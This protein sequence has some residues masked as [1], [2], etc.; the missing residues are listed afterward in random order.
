MLNKRKKPSIYVHMAMITCIALL[1]ILG[2]FQSVW[3]LGGSASSIMVQCGLQRTRM[4]AI[5]K[6]VLILAYRP[7]AD[8]AQAIGE[9]QIVLPLW[10]QTQK[11]L[12]V[13]D[14]TLM[15]PAHVPETVQALMIASQS[16]YLAIDTAAKKIIADGPVDP[17]QAQIILNHEHSYAVEMTQVNN[18]WQLQIDGAFLHIFWIESGITLLVIVLLLLLYIRSRIEDRKHRRAKN[19]NQQSF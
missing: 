4:Q 5:T 1:I 17:I 6:D 19:I 14:T 2:L 13:G 16:D 11:G 10:E 3:V 9:L 15:L 8:H 18:A 12:Q 7:T